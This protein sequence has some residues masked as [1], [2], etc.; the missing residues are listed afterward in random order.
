MGREQP[1]ST[2]NVYYVDMEKRFED[3]KNGTIDMRALHPMVFDENNVALAVRQ[4]NHSPG[5]MALGPDGTNYKTLES[6]S[7]VELAAIV[8][9]RL[10][11]K[12][13]SYVRRTYIAKDKK[14]TKPGY[15][16]D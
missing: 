1:M 15:P 12:T 14:K 5:K 9:E 16:L 6:Y 10:I 11:N 8:K 4:L 3:F 7:I 2:N 13:M